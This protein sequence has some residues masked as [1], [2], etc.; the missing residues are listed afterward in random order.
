MHS[1]SEYF[2]LG[3]L[4]ERLAFLRKRA[5]RDNAGRFAS[6]MAK[7]AFFAAGGGGLRHA[8]S[9]LVSGRA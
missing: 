2:A 9:T 3:T 6:T 8:T 5:G 4:A 7:N 1:A